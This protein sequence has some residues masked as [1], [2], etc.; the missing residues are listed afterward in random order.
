MTNRDHGEAIKSPASFSKRIWGL[1]WS[2]ILPWQLDEV[3]VISADFE[4][5]AAPFIRDNY[6]K[7][8]DAESNEKRFLASPP[9]DAKTRFCAEADTFVFR[10][11]RKTIGIFM[12]H[13]T[14]WST[15]YMRTAALL[16]AY[17]G[18][19]LV[20]RFMD[21]ICEP[22]R[23]AGVERLEGDISPANT[24]MLKLHLGQ[25]F[26]V[27]SSANSERWGSYLRFTKFLREEADT[28]FR[29]QFCN[30]PAI[31]EITKSQPKERR[32]S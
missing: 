17:R 26:L 9:S 21:R 30:T 28:V 27:T 12:A 3:E 5:G 24:P 8:F 7:I 18:R 6:A 16:P 11:E 31:T 32:L 4:E 20:A 2:T 14:D 15:Y 10:V 22:L 23:L 29:R 25:G 13:P 1:D 19:G